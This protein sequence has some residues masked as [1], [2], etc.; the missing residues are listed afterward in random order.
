[1]KIQCTCGDQF[2]DQTDFL[3][4][5]FS[6]QDWFDFLNAIDNAIEKSGPHNLDKERAVRNVGILANKLKKLFYSFFVLR[7]RMEETIN[8]YFKTCICLPTAENEGI[9]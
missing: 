9:W 7:K 3:R 1:M 8:N 2:V 6:D 4:H 5:V